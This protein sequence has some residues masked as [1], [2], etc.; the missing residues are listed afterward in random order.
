MPNCLFCTMDDSRIIAS[1]DLAYAIR[2]GFP[3]TEGH[4]LIIPNRHV[5]D[6]FGLSQDELLACDALLN[7]LKEKIQQDDSSVAGFN[8]GI[9]AGEVAGQTIFHC[10]IHLIPR[11]KG[12]AEEPRGGVRHVI[13]GKGF[14]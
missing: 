5:E 2:D 1:N 9:N 11:R 12:D 8:V 4:T 14:Y 6:Y 7:S 13:P 10:H 3:V